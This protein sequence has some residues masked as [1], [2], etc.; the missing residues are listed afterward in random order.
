MENIERVRLIDLPIATIYHTISMLLEPSE[1]AALSST[2]AYLNVMFSYDRY[3]LEYA[4]KKF[5]APRGLLYPPLEL[6]HSVVQ[7]TCTSEYNT[8]RPLIVAAL[9]SSSQDQE[10]ESPENTLKYSH[11][12][13][14]ICSLSSKSEAYVCYLSQVNCGCSFGNSCYWSSR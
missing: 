13:R 8:A 12:Y 3:W 9:D 10:C 11:C 5:V 1:F 14:E 2:C 6:C 4:L 7:A